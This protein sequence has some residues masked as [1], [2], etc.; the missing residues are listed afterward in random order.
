VP[1]WAGVSASLRDVIPPKQ[2][3]PRPAN[4][5]VQ[6]FVRALAGEDSANGQ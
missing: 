2:W 5:E 4:G 1:N 3:N 6:A